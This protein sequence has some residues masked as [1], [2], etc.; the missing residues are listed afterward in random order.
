MSMAII[1]A[2]TNGIIADKIIGIC[3]ILLRWKRREF[4]KHINSDNKIAPKRLYSIFNKILFMAILS[5]A[6]INATSVIVSTIHVIANNV[7]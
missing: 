6:C 2:E 5:K 7:K 4:D 3:F 1:I